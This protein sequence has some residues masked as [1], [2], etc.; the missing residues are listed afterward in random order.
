MHCG[1]EARVRFTI[2]TRSFERLRER[3]AANARS[4]RLDFLAGVLPASPWEELR[5]RHSGDVKVSIVDEMSPT[6]AQRRAAAVRRF[7]GIRVAMP[8]PRLPV[9]DHGD[10]DRPGIAPAATAPMRARARLTNSQSVGPARNRV[11]VV[12]AAETR[13][14]LT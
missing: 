7:E 14:N 12:R 13:S 1:S 11:P 9:R 4:S 2:L 10:G 6:S 5:C 8:P 3:G